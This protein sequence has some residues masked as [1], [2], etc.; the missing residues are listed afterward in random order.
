M[1][2]SFRW[3]GWE[4][5]QW[6]GVDASRRL[7]V[8]TPRTH[9]S[10]P[11]PD[12][13]PDGAPRGDCGRAAEGRDEEDGVGR[14]LLHPA[15]HEAGAAT[16][17]DKPQQA[18]PARAGQ[19]PRRGLVPARRPAGGPRGA[20]TSVC[21]CQ[22]TH[23][24]PIPHQIP[25]QSL[26]RPRRTW[27]A[28]TL[29]ASTSTRSGCRRCWRWRATSTIGEQTSCS[30]TC[31]SPGPTW[32]RWRPRKSPRLQGLKGTTV[33]CLPGESRCCTGA[34]CDQRRPQ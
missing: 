8:S 20:R 18:H 31:G 15:S 28:A 13:P 19:V 32:V 2:E 16:G 33:R 22:E 3:R 30:C 11:T 17:A 4:A 14:S 12:L 7:Y 24:L 1:I 5:A 34:F 26:A 21:L 27:R 10:L 9:P 25:H 23:F 6:E 29:A